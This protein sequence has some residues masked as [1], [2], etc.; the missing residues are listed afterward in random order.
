[1]CWSPG[2]RGSSAPRWSLASSR[3]GHSVSPGWSATGLRPTPVGPPASDRSPGTP[4]A[5]PID[6]AGARRAPDP[7]TASSIWPAPAWATSGGAPARKQ[8]ILDSRTECDPAAGRPRSSR[9]ASPPP[10]LVSASAVGF[11]GDRGDEVLDRGV[12]AGHRLPGRGVRG[13]GGGDRTG[14]RGRHPD[15]SLRTGHR[16]Q[17]HGRRAGQAAPPVPPGSRGPDRLGSPVPELDHPGRPD[18]R[19]PPL[20]R[21][22]RHC[23]DR[24]MPP[25][26]SR[27]PT[28]NWPR[29]IGG[30]LHRPTLLAVPAPALKLV[31]GTEMAGRPGPRRA[32]GSCPRSSSPRDSPSPT[33]TSTRRSEACC[34]P[35]GEGRAE[36][37]AASGSV[38]GD[39]N[40]K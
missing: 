19:H 39:H 17:R 6:I 28:P 2:L 32:S 30:V 12:A 3:G 1:M 37:R 23:P 5:G 31:L 33:P 7:S 29:R 13:L 4:T 16:A 22:R 15:G 24:S 26:P 40:S 25:P 34:P 38:P 8:V 35:G 20:P 10:V 21:R 9:S 11:Y 36:G 18:R 14:G 27:P